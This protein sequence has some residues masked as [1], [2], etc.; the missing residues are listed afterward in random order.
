MEILKQNKQSRPKTIVSAIC[1][2][3]HFSNPNTFEI[4]FTLLF[5]GVISRLISFLGH[6]GKY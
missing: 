1:H 2:R 6:D 4:I 5:V 3:H